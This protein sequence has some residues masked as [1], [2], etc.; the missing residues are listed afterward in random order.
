M[1]RPLGME[2][3]PLKKAPVDTG[4][5]I[6]GWCFPHADP[7]CE[8]CLR[9]GPAQLGADMRQF[10]QGITY[11]RGCWFSPWGRKSRNMPSD[12]PRP[13][14]HAGRE[15]APGHTRSYIR[16]WCFP[17]GGPPSRKMLSETTIIG[18]RVP[19]IPNTGLG[20]TPL[21]RPARRRPQQGPKTKRPQRGSISKKGDPPSKTPPSSTPWGHIFTKG[22]VNVFPAQSLDCVQICLYIVLWKVNHPT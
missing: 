13:A 9:M 8:K 12:L 16:I 6:R 4:S 21:V 20:R 14:G 7:N 11:I 15:L 1:L 17:R 19:P 5:Y 2:L 10:F 3:V 18:A 22:V